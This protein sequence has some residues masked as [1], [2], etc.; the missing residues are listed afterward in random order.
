M[1]AFARDAAVQTANASGTATAA[2]VAAAV[3]AAAS[4]AA[5]GALSAAAAQRKLVRQQA[6]SSTLLPFALG[7]LIE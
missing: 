6:R 4:A 5:V 7:L 1:V 2:Q 3:E